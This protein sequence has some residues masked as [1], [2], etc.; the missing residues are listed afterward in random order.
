VTA[1]EFSSDICAW[2]VELKSRLA[3]NPNPVM[4]HPTVNPARLPHDF[5]RLVTKNISALLLSARTPAPMAFRRA[6]LEKW[7]NGK[8]TGTKN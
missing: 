7:P 2:E 3:P 6:T 1:R 8:Q 4:M 5:N